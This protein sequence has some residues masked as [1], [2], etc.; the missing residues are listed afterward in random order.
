MLGLCDVIFLCSVSRRAYC[1]RSADP[2]GHA[3]YISPRVSGH[4]FHLQLSRHTLPC[5]LF[6]GSS[7]GQIMSDS[8]GFESEGFDDDAESLPVSFSALSTDRKCALV[9]EQIADSALDVPRSGAMQNAVAGQP[10]PGQG[11]HAALLSYGL[12]SLGSFSA[13]NRHFLL[14]I[15]FHA[16]TAIAWTSWPHHLKVRWLRT[17]ALPLTLKQTEVGT[18]RRHRE[19]HRKTHMQTQTRTH[20]HTSTYGHTHT[21]LLSWLTFLTSGPATFEWIH[22]FLHEVNRVDQSE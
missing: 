12:E 6:S 18:G 17:D 16:F 10:R 7:R 14:F 15:R 5:W 3:A 20:F 4:D 13:R 21:R 19:T 1:A 11:K 8:D 2:A 22:C 9:T